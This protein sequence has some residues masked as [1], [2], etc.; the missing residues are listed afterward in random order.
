MKSK[1]LRE[2]ST[3]DLMRQADK[4][5]ESLAERVSQRYI[6]DDKKVRDLRRIKKDIARVLT[7]AHAQRVR[8]AGT[9]E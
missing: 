9:E 3:K 4:L 8:N 6:K 7:I 1:D 5:R 2:K